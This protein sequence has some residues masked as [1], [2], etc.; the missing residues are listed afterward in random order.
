MDYVFELEDKTGRKIHLTKER[1]GHITTKHPDM[2]SQLEE[3]KHTLIYPTLIVPHKF[4]DTMRN[5]YTYYKHKKRYLL[6][7]V[8]Y[9][10]GEGYV[11]T[12]FIIRKIIKR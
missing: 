12:A 4:E 11:A 7:S 1:W 9:L 8:K 2:T 6:V 10:N 3:I 5:Y